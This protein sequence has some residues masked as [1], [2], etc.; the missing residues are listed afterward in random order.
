MKYFVNYTNRQESNTIGEF[1]T[2]VKALQFIAEE[3]RCKT[4]DIS[5]LGFDDEDSRDQFCYDVYAEGELEPVYS[6]PCFWE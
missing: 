5:G 6:S 2:L 4:E 3:T 1:D